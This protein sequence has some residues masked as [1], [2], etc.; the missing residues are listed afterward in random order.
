MKIRPGIELANLTDIGCERTENED[1]F[2]Y[3]EP[4]SD[5]EL[6]KR[7]RLV[8]IADGMGGQ[9]GGQIASGI[10]VDTVREIFLNGP[11]GD[12]AAALEA[13]YLSAHLAI[14]NYAR[15]HPDV[16]GMG[17]TCT[18]A[19][20]HDGHLTY[21]HV[22]DSRLYL[23][24]GGTIGRLTRDQSYVQHMVEIGV[25][26]PEEAA[27]HPSRNI[28]TSALGA[29][30]NVEADFAEAPIRLE[31][32]DVLLFCTDGL[33]GQVSD[34]EMLAAASENSPREACVK[35]VELAKS[36]GGPD[37]ITIQI[38]RIEGTP[39]A[40]QEDAAKAAS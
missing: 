4:E 33:H 11:A 16:A 37:N 38:V 27:T 34:D 40:S 32:A 23:L 2:C 7:G 22:G 20:L 39:E 21:G 28:L 26:S 35:L 3:A 19:V 14:Q 18:S 1:S 12:P 5:E 29:A 13:A 31:S 8:V 25:I 30:A 10:A 6:L 24:R 9:E 36:R 17:T 15:E